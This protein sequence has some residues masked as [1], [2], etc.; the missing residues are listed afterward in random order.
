MTE[1]GLYAAVTFVVVFLSMALFEWLNAE[2]EERK[3]RKMIDEE[4]AD[5]SPVRYRMIRV[6]DGDDRG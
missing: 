5:D 6:D 1:I 4:L 2:I 3:W